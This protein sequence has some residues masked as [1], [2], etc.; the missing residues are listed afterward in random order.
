MADVNVAVSPQSV[1]V[2]VERVCRLVARPVVHP[3]LAGREVLLTILGRLTPLEKGTAITFSR[4]GWGLCQ[5]LG[6]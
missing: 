1:D 6:S 3:E 5:P 2:G 4:L